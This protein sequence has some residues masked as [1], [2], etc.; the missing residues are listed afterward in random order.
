PL[1]LKIA[2]GILTLALPG[3]VLYFATR[4]RPTEQ[5]QVAKRVTPEEAPPSLVEPEKPG[6]RTSP[7]A[8]EKPPVKSSGGG[9]RT[10]SGGATREQGEIPVRSLVNVRTIYVE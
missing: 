4:G 5:Q 1:T 10:Q 3:S 2:I 6:A 7:A 9:S 8:P